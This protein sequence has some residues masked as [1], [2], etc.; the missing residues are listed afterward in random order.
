[1]AGWSILTSRTVLDCDENVVSCRNNGSCK[2]VEDGVDDDNCDGYKVRPR[3]IFDQVLSLFLK[4]VAEKGV[5]RP[6]PAMLGGGQQVDLFKLF[7]TVRDRGGHDRVSKKKLWA[8]VAKKS[9]LSLG[10]SAAVK[11]IYFKYVN[12]LVKWFRGMR[13]DRSLGNE[14]YGFDKNVQFLSLELETEF[15][16]LL[17][18]GSVRKGKN[19]G[20]IQ[21]ESDNEDSYRTSSGFGKYHSD[22]DEKSRH[23]DD[24]DL[25]IL[26]LNVDKKG[27]EW[28]RKRESLSGMLKWLI[29]TAKRSDDPS[30]GMIPEPSKW[31][32]HKDNEFWLQAIRVREALFLR[33]HICSNTEE[34]PLPKKQKM[35]PSMYE[36]N[37]AS[38]HHS[39]ER[40]RCSERVPNLVKSRLCACCNSRS[41]SQSKLRSPCKLELGK[42][43]KEEAPAE[44]DL[45]VTDTEVSPPK[46]EPLEK[47]VSVGPLFQADVPEWTGVVAESDPKWLGMQVWPVDCGAYKSYVETDSIGQGRSDFC[48]CPLRGSVECVRFHIA[49]AKMKLKLQLGSVFYHWRFDRMGEEVSLQWT[50]E[51]EKRFKD[52]VRSHNKCFWD[53]V[54]KWFPTKTQEKLVSYYFNVF[55]IQRR[56][57]QNRV[58]PKNI[59][60]DDDETELGSLSEGFGHDAVKVSGSNSLSCSKNEQCFDFEQT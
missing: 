23:D 51:E 52:I 39:T 28:K 3:C 1:M 37:M 15:R 26:D 11:L 47:H 53:D 20:P 10:A 46:D 8:S 35:H 2:S 43:P 56:S 14:Q 16:G 22:N 18:N 44:V 21:L 59:D 7:R 54:V 45:S 36:D 6:V 32:D 57:Y 48:G 38:S 34:S 19:G 31:K 27:K 42:D 41:S 17:S 58:T 9:G 24:G 49:E 5:L 55:L 60:S 33:R 4:E 25:Q 12:E 50:A 29:Q 40:L 13:K 30:I